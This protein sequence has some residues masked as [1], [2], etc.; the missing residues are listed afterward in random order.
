MLMTYGDLSIANAIS[1]RFSQQSVSSS[2]LERKSVTLW[3]ISI[4]YQLS[5]KQNIQL[6]INNINNQ[7]YYG[8]FDADAALQ[9][10]RSVRIATSWRF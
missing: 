8:S 3:D 5:D 4:D 7:T 6:A 9:S 10:E 1:H 2:E